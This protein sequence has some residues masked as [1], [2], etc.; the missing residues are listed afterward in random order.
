MMVLIRITN[1]CLLG[2]G[3]TLISLSVAS[4]L[5]FF[6]VGLA[7]F[8][9]LIYVMAVCIMGLLLAFSSAS[10]Y[11]YWYKFSSILGFSCALLVAIVGIGYTLSGYYTMAL[12]IYPSEANRLGLGIAITI[13]RIS[14]FFYG[15][16]STFLFFETRNGELG[17][18]GGILVLLFSSSSFLFVFFSEFIMTLPG[19][20]FTLL[21]GI[22]YVLQ[23]VALD[24]IFGPLKFVY[25][26]PSRKKQIDLFG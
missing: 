18:Y 9:V 19:A 10:F 16:L 25:P 1:K 6:V 22:G 4:V 3:L 7:Q 8:M 24:R 14:L 21:A 12:A 2:A 23:G 17:G 15:F 5:K 11:V 20:I 13:I 26:P